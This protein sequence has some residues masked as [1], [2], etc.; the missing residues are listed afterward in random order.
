MVEAPVGI[1]CPVCAGV[2][3]EGAVGEAAYRAR[4]TIERTRVGRKMTGRS[5]TGV[6]IGL[7]LLAALFTLLPN[8][9]GVAG[10]TPAGMLLR[11]LPR[12][13]VWRL[14][15]S[16]FIHLSLMHIAFNMYALSMFG[17]NIE[18][19]YGRARY[20]LLYLLSGLG[21]AAASLNLA[22]PG[23][24]AGAS[25]AIFGLFGAWLGFFLLHRHLPGAR[26]Q[27]Q[28]LLMLLGINAAIGFL[29]PGIDFWAHGGGLATGFVLVLVFELGARM[30]DAAWV[31]GLGVAAVAVAVAIAIVAGSA[32]AGF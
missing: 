30:G 7:N 8:L 26:E 25:G 28:S 22:G 24:S 4:T 3:K 2:M 20:L 15:T 31:Q 29:F 5:V 11:P 23:A 14:F 16:M 21:G 12:D 18:T 13:E 9:M 1:H 32:P 19:R 6:L 27:L 17:P 10:L